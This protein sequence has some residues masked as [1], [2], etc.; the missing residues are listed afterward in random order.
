MSSE[1]IIRTTKRAPV[2]G[3][4]ALKL[5]SELSYTAIL[6]ECPQMYLYFD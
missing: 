5:R 4:S 2:A 1:T 6:R 3:V